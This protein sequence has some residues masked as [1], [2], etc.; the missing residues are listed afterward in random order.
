M[1]YFLQ[2]A[3]D[4]EIQ[5]AMIIGNTG[6]CIVCFQRSVD[7]PIELIA[8]PRRREWVFDDILIVYAPRC[9]DS[10]IM[11]KGKLHQCSRLPVDTVTHEIS[12]YTDFHIQ[13]SPFMFL[14]DK[15]S[16]LRSLIIY[17]S[18]SH[19]ICGQFA[20]ERQTFYLSYTVLL[21]PDIEFRHIFSCRG[22]N[23]LCSQCQKTILFRI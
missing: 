11:K 1:T 16:G 2:I 15:H 13:S 6:N 20:A 14:I 4:R 7:I 8:V 12:S 17:D 18:I 5:S 19:M 10:E 22:I 9:R 21:I 3:F 23:M